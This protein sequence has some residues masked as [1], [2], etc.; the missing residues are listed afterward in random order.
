MKKRKE[1]AYFPTGSLLRQIHQER[2]VGLLYGQR[3]LAVGAAHPLNYTATAIHSTG[4]A[5]PFTRLA[6]T[7][8]AIEAV[9]LG[10]R[11]QADEALAAVNDLHRT[12]N[13]RLPCDAGTYP[14]GTRYSAFDPELML[15]TV[16]II[17][18]SAVYFFELLIH[19]LTAAEREAAWQD[20]R[21][22]AEL[23]KLPQATMPAT[24]PEFREW[25]LERMDSSD[26]CLTPEARQTGYAV[27]FKIPMPRCV[28]VMQQEHNAILLG[29]LPSQVRSLYG[30]P[31]TPQDEA[32]FIAA[33]E[34]ARARLQHLPRRLTRGRNGLFFSWIARNE[35][36]QLRH[37][38]PALQISR[39]TPDSSLSNAL[40]R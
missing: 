28:A 23:F 16:A 33:T 15:W 6:R 7:A 19:Q 35:R 1:S 4:R 17:A 11:R 24:F 30:L 20:Y 34:R 29:S 37:G 9:I 26:L 2:A 12:V 22:F 25:W 32:R 13:G 36:L 3:A 8:R 14:A 5:R 18:D 31:Y 40:I 38:E 27:A 39:P 10:S 21:R